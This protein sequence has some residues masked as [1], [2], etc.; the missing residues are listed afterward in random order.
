[1]TNLS[2]EILL[3]IQRAQGRSPTRCIMPLSHLRSL[4]YDQVRDLMSQL[5]ID[6]NDK[7]HD[8]LIEIQKAQSQTS[9]QCI[10]SM[11]HLKSLTSDQIQNLAIHLEID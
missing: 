7:S 11:R 6:S 2:L 1:M 5:E 10:M 8:I 3:K 4:T 9:S